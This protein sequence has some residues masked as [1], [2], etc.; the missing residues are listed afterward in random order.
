MRAKE[1]FAAALKAVGMSQAAVARKVGMPPQSVG[2]KINTRETITANE[3]FAILDAMGIGSYFYVK[4][5]GEV[6]MRDA[7]HGRRVSGFSDGVIYDTKDSTIVASSFF[8]DGKE[9]YGPDG[10]AQ[11]LYRDRN[12]RYFVAEYTKDG[13]MRDRV[14]AV[15]DA[16]AEA[17]IQKF[18]IKDEKK[19]V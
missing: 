1:I 2:Q 4:G 7:S 12:G 13:S 3:F 10:K 5:T 11:E 9:E 18:G 6:L 14:R 17:F 19:P 16:M 8:A 15:P